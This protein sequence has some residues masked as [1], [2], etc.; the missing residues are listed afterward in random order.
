MNN[1][2]LYIAGMGMVT[3]LGANLA[4]SCA[5]V[6][7]QIS[8]YESSGYTTKSNKA[9]TL[10]VVPNE[11]FDNETWEIDEGESAYNLQYDHMIKMGLL[12]LEETLAGQK[13]DGKVP[14]ILA[15][16]EAELAPS[17]SQKL[18]IR[19]FVSH[20]PEQ[21]SQELSRSCHNGR[22]AGIAC[23]DFAFQYL[24]DKFDYCLVGGS[25]SYRDSNRLDLLDNQNRLLTEGAA[26]AF[27]PGQGACFLLLTPRIENAIATNGYAIAITRPGLSEE[28]GHLY[29]DELYKG[30]GLDKAFKRALADCATNLIS[31]VYSTMNGENY[32]A[33]EYG[34]AYLRNRQWFT[35]GVRLEHPAD[36]YGDLG[37]A[38]TTA[39]IALAACHL[40]KQN[41]ETHALVYGSSDTA[42]RGALVIEKVAV[43]Q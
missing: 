8:A 5:A 26:D 21:L 28:A 19:N 39:L 42:M 32:W 27:A 31:R 33:K 6:E 43:N 11:L 2:K 1:K 22:A 18:I 7:A 9:I 17:V 37:A 35:D 25:D 20:F 10:C 36:C 30:G 16:P 40:L 15:M 14:L 34:V 23:I 4:L 12:A 41:K 38:S 24:I 3:P 29:S 13:L